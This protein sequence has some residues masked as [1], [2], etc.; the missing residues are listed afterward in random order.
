MKLFTRWTK[1]KYTWIKLGF[2]CLGV[3]WTT[4]TIP[5]L[6]HKMKCIG[7]RSCREPEY[8]KK[9][10][11]VSKGKT[12][13]VTFFMYVDHLV[14][15]AKLWKWPC[16]SV[17]FKS[18]GYVRRFQLSINFVH[19]SQQVAIE[20]EA[21]GEAIITDLNLQR[22]ALERTRTMLHE[23]DHDLTRSRRILKRMAVSTVY[24]KIIL[25]FIII[26]QVHTFFL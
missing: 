22:E 18:F 17:S 2:F 9:R 6:S 7:I 4:Q 14:H 25:I 12:N 11:K 5:I 15:K 20:T 1:N 13:L 10:R 24:N 16:S 26:I 19:R 23:T 21:V 3:D 8:S